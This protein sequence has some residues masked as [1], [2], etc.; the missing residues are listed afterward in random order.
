MIKFEPIY[1]RCP[2]CNSWLEGHKLRPE[3]VN[4]SILYSDGKTLNDDYIMEPQKIIICPGCGHWFWIDS[5]EEPVIT[6][7]K[8]A[9]WCYG[10]NTW[11]FFGVHFTSNEGKSA[12]IEHYKDILAITH[13]T[14]REIYLRRMLWWSYNDLIR[15][16]YQASLS[17]LFSGEM[18]F[19]VWRKNRLKILKGISLFRQ[20]HDDYIDNCMALLNL[21]KDRYT[22]NDDEYEKS[23]LEIMELYRE[24]GQYEKA[25]EILNTV[26]RRTHYIANIEKYVRQRKDFVFLVV[27]R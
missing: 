19:N 14:D 25:Q 8:P 7:T 20:H 4:S 1:L 23:I 22:P 15:N 10:W 24:T 21:V 18:S 3:M 17:Y 27:G 11:R 26:P 13:D 6:K 16:F 5:Y 9:E 12:L 2:Q